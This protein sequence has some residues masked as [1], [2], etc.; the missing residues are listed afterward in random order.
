[1]QFYFSLL[2]FAVARDANLKAG[3]EMQD[4]KKIKKVARLI[5]RNKVKLNI[6]LQAKEVNFLKNISQE[7]YT[8]T[9]AQLN[10]FYAIHSKIITVNL[11]QYIKSLEDKI[12][13]IKD[14][15][16]LIKL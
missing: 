3:V 15:I 9:Q 2:I 7:N 11:T 5:L 6:I 4:V 8:I 16:S 14:F 1:L 13:D 12:N 10:Y